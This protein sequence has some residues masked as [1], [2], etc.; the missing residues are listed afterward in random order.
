MKKH[1][2]K[3]LVWLA[4]KLDQSVEKKDG[5]VARQVGIGIHITKN[6][7]K[8]FRKVNPQYKSHREG[9]KALVEDTKRKAVI[10]LVEGMRQ[11]GVIDYKVNSSLWTADV[12][13]KIGVY[14]P[15]EKV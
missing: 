13:V 14:V 11:N 10:N 5:Y 1:L 6:D 15:K 4:G 2:A 8:K 7:V 9:L 12:K 3:M